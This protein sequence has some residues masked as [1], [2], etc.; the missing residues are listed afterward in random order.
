MTHS[1]HNTHP[2]P[3]GTGMTACGVWSG[4]F[5]F[6]DCPH[7][8]RTS[9]AACTRTLYMLG[10]VCF[11]CCLFFH[12]R[13]LDQL[14]Q[15]LLGRHRSYQTLRSHVGSVYS[16]V[17]PLLLEHLYD[18]SRIAFVLVQ[19]QYL[20]VSFFGMALRACF[21]AYYVGLLL[22]T[23]ARVTIVPFSEHFTSLNYF[24][25]IVCSTYALTHFFAG[26]LSV[27]AVL[28]F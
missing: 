8:P 9:S 28:L 12:A 19:E 16:L 22:V 25:N 26:H 24:K 13:L 15:D 21:K 11:P 17:N 7:Q 4:I 10:S 27:T 20:L 18:D 6:V 2:G 3:D 1:L 5:Q 14:L 23:A